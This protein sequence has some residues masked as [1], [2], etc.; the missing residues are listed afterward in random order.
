[1]HSK[2]RSVV[3]KNSSSSLRASA[4]ESL[5]S[6]TML[7]AAPDLSM[8]VV[9]PASVVAGTD[10]T[11]TFTTVNEG[12]VTANPIKYTPPVGYPSGCSQVSFA[13]TSGP[14]VLKPGQS[15]VFTLVLAVNAYVANATVLNFPIEVTTPK[16]NSS[17]NSTVTINTPVTTSA[18]LNLVVTGPAEVT[19]GTEATFTF[20]TINAGPSTETT[21]LYTPPDDF[22]AGFS[23]ISYTLISGPGFALAPGDQDVYALVMSVSPTIANGTVAS[24]P[25]VLTGGISDPNPSNNT[26]TVSTT[27]VSQVVSPVSI[28]LTSSAFNS[29]AAIGTSVGFTA[30]VAPVTPGGATPT[31]TVTFTDNGN[32]LGTETVDSNGTATLPATSALTSGYH[33]IIASYSG[34]TTYG[35]TTKSMT[36]VVTVPVPST[37]VPALG[38]VVLPTAVVAGAKFNAAVPVTITNNGSSQ[39]G[40]FKIDL[41][42]DTGTTLD[43]NQ[44]SV[45]PEYEK[46]LTLATDK[47]AAYTFKLKSLP[48]T[49][50]AGTYHLIAVVTDALT[51]NNSV[52][53][54]QTI[55]TAAPFVSLTG[56]ATAVTPSSIAA[57]KTG[58]ISVSIT[59]GGN[60][61][62]SGPLVIT[63]A[64]S[65]DG[66][67]PVAGATFGSLTI[68]NAVIKPGK[69][70]KYTLHIKNTALTA[71][72]FYPYI[73]ATL[74]SKTVTLIGTSQFT[75]G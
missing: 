3:K 23:Q 69:I 57:N 66:V 36:E 4:I 29:T 75:I 10:A 58:S 47:H 42:A 30:A 28:T 43:G 65:A 31:G 54:T 72:T 51:L 17:P 68:P 22:P 37:V 50:A 45:A 12:K 52:A 32:V 15:Q 11:Y 24:F 14:A 26:A 44:V 20:A 61:A 70:G 53:T 60:I 64:P 2:S 39:T 41:Y 34:D 21:G 6:R 71:G 18:D 40:I 7:S 63:L 74:D 49:L 67:S 16:G 55:T 27:V 59:N 8:S 35:A 48:A 13:L 46:Q 9:G 19:R 73:T 25:A 56:T 5:E 33:T 62:T 38:K 1:M